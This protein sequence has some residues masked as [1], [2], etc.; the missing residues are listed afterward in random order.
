MGIGLSCSAMSTAVH[1]QQI[2]IIVNP[3]NPI[4]QMTQEQVTNLYLGITQD[5]PLL[6]KAI[7][8]DYADSAKI[9][10]DFII[11][12]L[13]KSLPTFRAWWARQMFSGKGNPPREMPTHNDMKRAVASVTDAI[14]YIDKAQVDNS[15]KVVLIVN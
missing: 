2:A 4:S 10:E 15:V 8:L 7:P 6:N 5:F 14:G 13:G 11:R 3:Q 1:A 9:K 12:V